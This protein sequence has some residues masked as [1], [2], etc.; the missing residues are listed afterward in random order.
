MYKQQGQQHE[1]NTNRGKNIVFKV[2]TT[3]A[4]VA[5]A[6]VELENIV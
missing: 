2:W 5:I 4:I 1:E 3:N 6:E